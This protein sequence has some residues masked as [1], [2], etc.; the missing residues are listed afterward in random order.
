MAFY[1]GTANDFAQLVTALRDACTANGWT[2]S[3][4]VLHKG[5]GYLQLTSSGTAL[6][7]RGGTGIDGSN[8]LTGA[9]PVIGRITQIAGQAVA[10]PVNYDIHVH[11]DPDEVYLIIKYNVE[12]HQWAAFGISD[13]QGV[14][15]TGLWFGASAHSTGVNTGITLGPESGGYQGNS[16]AC[17][18]LFFDNTT[19]YGDTALG[20]SIHHGLDGRGW[21]GHFG[22]NAG[23]NQ[24]FA[25][26]PA[27]PRYARQPSTV[28]A[29]SAMIDFKIWQR[30]PDAKISLVADLAHARLLRIDH[31]DPGELIPDGVD[32]WRAYPWYRKNSA[33]GAR[34]GGSNITHTGTLGW[35]IRY[36]G[37]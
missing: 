18:A 6:S 33:P 32:Q 21:S 37:P 16:Q 8:V 12:F 7:I 10:F 2:L 3:G 9:S 19:V 29:A 25:G 28:N 11:E 30:R 5:S 27:A 14:L 26:R 34:D 22:D 17:T 4:N 23:L 1:P 15:G 20:A 13:V 36:D 35:A 31:V 24:A